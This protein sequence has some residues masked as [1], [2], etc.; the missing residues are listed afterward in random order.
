[1]VSDKVSDAATQKVNV[2]LYHARQD[3][4]VIRHHY[5]KTLSRRIAKSAWPAPTSSP[6]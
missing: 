6:G 4:D 5:S 2:E 3:A 1:M